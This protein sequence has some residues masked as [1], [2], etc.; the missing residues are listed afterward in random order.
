[1]RFGVQMFGL[2]RAWH[3]DP[4]GLYAGLRR[5]RCASVEPCVCFG[6]KPEWARDF[7]GLWSGSGLLDELPRLKAYGLEVYSAHVFADSPGP[8]LADMVRLARSAGLRQI[9]LKAPAS[10]DRETLSAFAGELIPVSEALAAEGVQVLLHKEDREIRARI[11]GM[12]AM[13]WLLHRCGGRIG[14]QAA[15]GWLLAGG[16]DPEA[17][18]WRNEAYVRSLHWKDFII[19]AD[20][21]FRETPIGS[22]SLDTAACFRFARA[23]GIGQIADMDSGTPEN[24]ADALALLWSLRNERGGTSSTLCVLDVDNGGVTELLRSGDVIE[25]PN[26]LP[27]GDTI[28]YNTGGRIR[29]YRLSDG[30]DRAVDTGTCV[31]CNNDHVPSFDGRRLAVSHFPDTGEG[32]QSHIFVM[33][34]DGGAPAQV[35]EKSPS[36]LHG[37]SRDGELAYCAFRPDGNG[38]LRTVIAVLPEGGGEE[39]LLTHGEG[40]D[41]GPEY[42]PDGSG[43]WFCSTR[44]GRRQVWHMDRGGGSLRQVS[45]AD[46]N[47]WFPHISP[48]G[49]R[50]AYLTFRKDELDPDEHLPNMRVQ[51]RIMNADGSGDRPLLDLFGGQGT[52]NV[53]S[54]APDSRRLAF[55][56][57]ELA[58]R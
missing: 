13:E 41:D 46:A 34:L 15:V 36:F 16:E 35:T 26:W 6:E 57:Y 24:A 43:L 58:H 25:A 48:D 42:D 37:W 10:L 20:G 54:W 29:A 52:I 44:S 5:A 3:A 31:N 22:G 51:L 14:L 23:H 56:R 9:V 47:A 53:N 28:L 55:V 18:L 49:K 33:P 30:S 12:S 19:S 39:R 45:D 50:V 7:P 21:S 38:G 32:F 2:G 17:F 4:E 40:Y 27:D 8:A 1:M 11:D